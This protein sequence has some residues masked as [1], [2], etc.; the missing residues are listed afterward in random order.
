MLQLQM[1]GQGSGNP[2]LGV[3]GAVQVF[4][5][6]EGQIEDNVIYHPRP[7]HDQSG[8][9]Y[10]RERQDYNYGGN[11]GQLGPSASVL[12]TGAGLADF[13]LGNVGGR[14]PRRPQQHQFLGFAATSSVHTSQ[15]DWRVSSNLHREPGH[16]LRRPHAVLRSQE[17]GGGL[18]VLHR[19]I[20]THGAGTQVGNRALYNNYLG[21][22]DWQSRASDSPGHRRFNGQT[23]IRGGYAVSQY[24]EG[25][26]Q[27]GTYSESAVLWGMPSKHRRATSSAGFGPSIPSL[28]RY[29]FVLLLCR[30][31]NSRV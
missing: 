9:Q 14:F 1:V 15:D 22:G 25:G 24:L 11:N 27:R 10:W 18:R 30:R 21:I 13:W 26:A 4:H 19:G 16:S 6:T 28:R 8:F 7:P 29:H 12:R 20:Y 31:E 2:T 5:T 3:N 23:V 17:P